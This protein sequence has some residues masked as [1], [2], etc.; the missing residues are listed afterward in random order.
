MSYAV[1]LQPCCTW[2]WLQ[3]AAVTWSCHVWSRLHAHAYPTLPLRAVWISTQ[4]NAA[5]AARLLSRKGGAAVPAADSDDEEADG[6][7]SP[8][9]GQPAA[10]RQ[11]K[12]PANPL[13]DDRF[14]SMF[15]DQDFEIDMESEEYKLLHPNAGAGSTRLTLGFLQ[16]CRQQNVLS[17]PTG[18]TL[19]PPHFVNCMA[20]L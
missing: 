17:L 8:A 7:G 20:A 14:A 12:A 10:K 18:C 11:R 2:R 5:A 13:T 4:V 1:P 9:D 6:V 19:L 3:T 15:R 16:S